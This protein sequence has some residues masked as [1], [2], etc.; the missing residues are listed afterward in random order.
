VSHDNRRDGFATAVMCCS[1]MGMTSGVTAQR[2][3]PSSTDEIAF[4]R[5]EAW[6]M[7]YFM[8]ATALSGL[9]TPDSLK[10]GALA[11]DHRLQ[12]GEDLLVPENFAARVILGVM[13]PPKLENGRLRQRR[14]FEA[15]R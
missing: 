8:S 14:Q 4:E 10:V 13:A 5:P 6:A 1:L 3:S 2:S 12:G 11:A 9:S 15:A 7:K